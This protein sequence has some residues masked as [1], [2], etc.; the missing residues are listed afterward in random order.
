VDPLVEIAGLSKSCG[1][2]CPLRIAAL[3]VGPAE[4]VAIVGL[5]AAAAEVLVNLI[6]GAILPAE[7][8]VRVFGRPTSVIADADDWLATLDRFGLVSPRAVLPG[9]FTARQA[10]A[11]AFTL[12]LDPLAHGV[13]TDVERLSREAKLP[14][15]ALDQPLE[16]ADPLTKARCRLARALAPN[17]AV[18]VLEHANALVPAHAARFG[19]DIASIARRRGMAVVALTADAAFA[20]AVADRVLRL[21]AATGRL[22]ETAGWPWRPGR[23]TARTD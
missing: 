20:R 11:A 23:Q 18:L 19:G 1:G 12:S 5:D 9:G 2:R 7:G 10:I 21:D 13:S 16:G 15:A 8:E 17:P 3:S 6:I 4:R 22:A 14:R